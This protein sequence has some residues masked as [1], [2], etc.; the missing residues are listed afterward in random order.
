MCWVVSGEISALRVGSLY[1]FAIGSAT[2]SAV[3]RQTGT[4]LEISEVDKVGGEMSTM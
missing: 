1:A 3:A 2:R 4:I